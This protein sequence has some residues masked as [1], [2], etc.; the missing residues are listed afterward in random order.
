MK[1]ISSPSCRRC[2]T[3]C[4]K[5]GP[6]LHTGDLALLAAGHLARRH[7]ITLRRGEP[8]REN[9]A[10]GMAVL[11][12]EMVKIGGLGQ[13]WTCRLYQPAERACLIHAH[14]PAECRALFC[15]APEGLA[16][17]YTHDRL[18]RADIVGGNGALWE[19]ILY[20]DQA[21]PAEAA[22]ALARAAA[23]G[24][25]EALA[26]LADLAGRES[27]FR[28]AFLTRSQTDPAELDF[29][30]GRPLTV[31]ARAFGLAVVPR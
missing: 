22:C 30:F 19:L 29:Y 20:H 8:V 11:G 16:A 4:R 18:T 7:L 26:R 31:L 9:V 10:G 25:A 21:F 17:L 23:E 5:G 12:E 2:G 28:T 3:C 24:D 14:R 27:A 1:N 15:E 6:A 13:D